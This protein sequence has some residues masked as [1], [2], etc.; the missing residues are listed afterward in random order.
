MKKTK[1][2]YLVAVFAVSALLLSSVNAQTIPEE[3]RRHMAR[4]QAAVEIAKSPEDYAPAI[5]EF[6]EAARLAPDWPDP[7]YSM[8]FVQEKAGKFK[9]AIKSLNKYLRLAP[10]TAD[11]AKVKEH[12][13]KLEYKAENVLTPEDIADVLISFAKWE[14][15]G[16]CRREEILFG[17]IKREGPNRVR[18][19][20]SH[21][22]TP[23]EV[24]FTTLKVEGL[25]IK[26][27]TK[28]RSWSLDPGLIKIFGVEGWPH[29]NQIEVVSREHVI[30][31]QKVTD[32]RG[33]TQFFSCEYFKK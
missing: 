32:N 30:V 21:A 28:V 22:F 7:Y 1:A 3:A 11:A 24:E 20:T 29:E 13:Y 14:K 26:F 2:I 10:N 19:F 8:G 27:T 25:I 18:V 16:E 23:F 33:R 5:R 12:I 4:G 17:L 15:R 9:E 6:Q 31:K